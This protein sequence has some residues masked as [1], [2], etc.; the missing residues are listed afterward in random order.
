MG[1]AHT[2]ACYPASSNY[3]LFILCW[4]LLLFMWTSEMTITSTDSLTTLRTIEQMVRRILSSHEHDVQNLSCEIWLECYLNDKTPSWNFVR[5]RCYDML[6]AKQR[7]ELAIAQHQHH[8]PNEFDPEGVM[9]LLEKAKLPYLQH[10]ILYK[11]FWLNQTISAISSEYGLSQHSVSQLLG[12]AIET[13][14]ML[15]SRG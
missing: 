7:E 14:R 8:K 12:D 5:F 11:R 2:R 4:R 10:Q 9:H 15:G 13:L 1:S 3:G 6:R